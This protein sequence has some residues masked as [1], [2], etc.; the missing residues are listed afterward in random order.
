[1]FNYFFMVVA[2]RNYMIHR[3]TVTRQKSLMDNVK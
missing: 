1:M 2:E 3:V